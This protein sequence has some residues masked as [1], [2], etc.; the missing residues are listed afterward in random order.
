M[1]NKTGIVVPR[2]SYR[3]MFSR[4]FRRRSFSTATPV[5]V[6]YTF[7]TH[8]APWSSQVNQSPLNWNGVKQI[9]TAGL[10]K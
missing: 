9:R 5:F 7:P 3:K 8:G 2:A 6:N 1:S 4:I 10:D